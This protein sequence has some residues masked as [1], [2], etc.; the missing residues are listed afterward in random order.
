MAQIIRPSFTLNAADEQELLQRLLY[1]NNHTLESFA[2]YMGVEAPVLDESPTW[3]INYLSDLYDANL[4]RL[5][6]I[7]KDTK[8]EGMLGEYKSQEKIFK[9][10]NLTEPMGD[11]PIT[12]N[13][14]IIATGTYKISLLSNAE[15]L[16]RD[17]INHRML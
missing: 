9:E 12:I 5:G 4:D 7:M 6:Y 13:E 1:L 10:I 15:K 14:S 16:L 11:Q 2:A 17:T 8:H 3:A